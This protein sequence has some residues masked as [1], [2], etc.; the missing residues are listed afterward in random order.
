MSNF[1]LF[2]WL[3]VA[4]IVWAG[5]KIIFSRKVRNDFSSIKKNTDENATQ[6]PNLESSN[7]VK[8]KKLKGDGGRGI[9]VAGTQYHKE[10]LTK[11]FKK[12]LK[13]ERDGLDEEDMKDSSATITAIVN[14]VYEDDNPHDSNAVAIKL[15]NYTLGYLPRQF[16]AAFRNYVAQN[17]LSGYQ[18][19]CDA[20]IEMPLE[21][22]GEWEIKLDLPYLMPRKAI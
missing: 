11:A 1:S 13:E 21:E 7:L 9:Y 8:R 4:A 20:E 19:A 15:R 14:L 6:K 5:W 10:D 17:K 3:I 18:L 16:A 22:H 2:H 12:Q